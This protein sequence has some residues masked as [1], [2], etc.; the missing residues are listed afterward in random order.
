MVPTREKSD[1]RHRIFNVLLFI[2]TERGVVNNIVEVITRL[3]GW[4]KRRREAYHIRV[5]NHKFNTWKWELGLIIVVGLLFSISYYYPIL[6]SGYDLGIQDWDQNFAWTEANRVSILDYH[7][8]PLWNPYK[9]G[10]TAQFAN[11]QVPVISFQTLFALLFGTAKGIKISIFFHGLI[12]FIGFYFLAR[13]YK[14]WYIGSLLAATIF[15]FS[16]ITGSFLST[17]MVVFT[18]FAYIPYVLIYYNKGINQAKWGVVGGIFFALSFY[19]S[20]QIPLLLGIYL[21]VYTVVLSIIKKSIAPIKAFIILSISSTVLMLPKLML[22]I[23]LLQNYPRQIADISGYSP[24]NFFYFLLSMK[25][26]LFDEMDIQA[27][28]QKIDENSI[29]VGILAFILFLL[30]YIKNRAGVID[31]LALILTMLIIFWI[32]LG[33]EIFPSLYNAIRHLPIFSSFRVAQRFRFDFIIPFALLSGLGLDNLRRL[34]KSG[35][36]A[37]AISVVCLVAV[38]IDLTALSTINF[39]SKTLIILNPEKQLARQAQFIQTRAN[40]PDFRVE[41]TIILPESVRENITF[42]PWSYE[43]PKILENEGVLN[44]YDPIPLQV[45]AAGIGE[46]NYQGEYYLLEAGSKIRL[47]NS[48]WSP[49]KLTYDVYS[50]GGTINNSLIVNQN[51]YPGWIVEKDS[52]PCERAT[53]NKGLLEAKLNAPVERITFEFNLAKFYIFCR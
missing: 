8:F 18:N 11:P 34:L 51:Y 23:R 26:N 13:Q 48:Y 1:C 38:F 15:S 3:S 17:G 49:N 47:E 20:Y 6:T 10:G 46:A 2:P 35:K 42:D 40:S 43:Y 7:Q 45:Y 16:G 5:I 53:N 14:I 33:S 30:F 4:V 24:Y 29:Y 41:R 12:G 50:S 39:L 36:W 19:F 25:Q 37:G 21:L 27:Y 32:M 28:F 9:C 22:A 44:C 52:Q 31:H